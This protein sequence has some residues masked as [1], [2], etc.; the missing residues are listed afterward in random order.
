MPSPVA[1]AEKDRD[2]TGPAVPDRSEWPDFH[3]GVAAALRSKLDGIDSSQISFNRPGELDARHAGLLMG[4]GLNGQLGSMLSSQAYDYLKAKHDPTSVGILLGLAVTYLGTSDPTLTSVISIHLPALHPPR[5]SSLNVSGMTK[6][7]AAVALGLLHFGTGRRSFADVMVREMCGVKVT[8]V[9]DAAAC[10]EAYA[11]SCGFAFGYIMLGKGGKDSAATA[12][13]VDLLRVFRALIL[14]ENNRP[15]PGAFYS[16][17][18]NAPTDVNITSSAATV[19]LALM[20]IRS[21]RQD[22]ANIFEIPDSPRRLDYVRSDVLLLRSLC[23]SLVMWN[24]ITPSKE[25]IESGLPKFLVDAAAVQAL[26]PNKQMDPEWEV[27]RW[28]IIAGACFAVGFKFAG[29]ATAEAHATLIHYMDRLTR[30]CYVKGELTLPSRR[31]LELIDPVRPAVTVQS[32]IKR[33]SL[34]TCLGVVAIALSMVMAGTGELNVLRRLRVAHGH[35]SEGLAYGYHLSTHMALGLLF[36]GEARYTLS[37]SNGAIATLLLALYPSFP[38]TSTDN[39]AHL[40]AYRHLWVLAAE[41]R[42]LEARDIDSNEPVFLPV[43]LRLVD[44]ELARDKNNKTELKAKQLVAPTL[45]PDVRLLDSIQVESPRYWG[46]TVRLA[47]NPTQFSRFLRNSTLYVKR[48]TGHLSYAQDPRGIRSIF[49]RSKSE[50]GSSVYDFGETARMLNPSA[51]GLRDF[52]AAFSDDAEAI[53]ATEQLCIPPDANRPPTAFEAFSASVLLECLTKD[54]R[55]IA[56]VYHS[57]Y[58]ANTLLSPNL[59]PTSDTLLAAEQLRLV[60]DF[61]KRGIFKTLFGRSTS[62][63]KSKPPSS[64]S[65]EPLLNPAFID[66]LSSTLSSRI[67]SISSSSS[68]SN[69]LSSYLTFHTWPSSSTSTIPLSLQLAHHA[70]PDLAALEQL[71]QLVRVAQRSGVEEGEIAMRIQCTARIIQS[72]GKK[73]WSKQVTKLLSQS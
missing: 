36:L 11:L 18:A 16:A 41:P 12:N 34:R 33:H 7:A 55:D 45:I 27:A 73:V 59:N 69:H 53:A 60:V 68:S 48:R 63:S 38:S 15:L 51:A 64:N 42:Y 50:T 61:Y 4:L 6:S 40:Q 3:S 30:A 21:E 23:Q 44:R 32:K 35:F 24:S 57:I 14:G 52:V 37:N 46:F 20:F 62:T 10:R 71:S 22:V 67:D 26:D 43:R 25:W 56:S 28:S 54:K 49:T 5:S 47:Q 9:E 66:H 17:T 19:G 39:R 58:Y 31:E 29:T 70:V 2:P 72:T 13:E 1:L 65:R 8:N